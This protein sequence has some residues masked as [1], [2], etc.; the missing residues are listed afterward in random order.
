MAIALAVTVTFV[1]CGSDPTHQLIPTATPLPP[2][3]TPPP[4]R[5]QWI[6]LE[7]ETDPLTRVGETR[8]ALVAKGAERWPVLRIRCKEDEFNLYV[9]D[10][11]VGWSETPI[12]TR[13]APWGITVQHRIDDGPVESLEWN[14]STDH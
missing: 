12:A 6:T 4:F 1:A 3:A 13:N 14:F 5:G 7:D 11:I 9:L 8:I 2:T 10:F